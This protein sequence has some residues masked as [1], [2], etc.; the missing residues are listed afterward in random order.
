[1]VAG[2]PSEVIEF[3][4]GSGKMWRLILLAVLS[5]YRGWVPAPRGTVILAPLTLL[6]GGVVLPSLESPV[7]AA[8]IT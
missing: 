1:M 7:V 3:G 5:R 6:G 4:R 2:F 8:A